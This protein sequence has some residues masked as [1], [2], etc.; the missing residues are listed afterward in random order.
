MKNILIIILL[1]YIFFIFQTSF[2]VHFDIK[3]IVP[4]LVLIAVFLM[5]ILENPESYNGI[6]VAVIFGFFWDIFSEKFIGFH[7]L[8]L[9]FIAFLIKAIL[10]RYVRL[11]VA[12]KS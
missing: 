7:I 1:T 2:L 10:K 6:L 8:I 11:H 4:N 5:N 12:E 9:T 3:R